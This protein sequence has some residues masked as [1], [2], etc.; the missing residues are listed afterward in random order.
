MLQSSFNASGKIDL[1]WQ[2]NRDGDKD[3]VFNYED[4]AGVESDFIAT[5]SQ[6]EFFV[7]RFIGDREKV[8]SLTNGAGISFPVYTTDT[9]SVSGTAVQSRVEEGEYYFELYNVTEKRTYV[10]GKLFFTYDPQE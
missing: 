7:K 10:S 4:D 6:W 2:I 5:S 9:V 8:M 1:Y 3:F